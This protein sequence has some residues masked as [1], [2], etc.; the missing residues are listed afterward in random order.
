MPVCRPKG[1]VFQEPPAEVP[2]AADQT[3]SGRDIRLLLLFGLQDNDFDNVGMKLIVIE[4]RSGRSPMR[5]ADTRDHRRDLLRGLVLTA[6]VE[7]HLP[8][9]VHTFQP[10][11][12]LCDRHKFA[13]LAHGSREYTKYS[14]AVNGDKYTL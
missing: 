7:Q 13:I 4:H 12:K 5:Q 6:S 11:N 3:A 1:L 10:L 2:Q 9:L 14:R 8:P